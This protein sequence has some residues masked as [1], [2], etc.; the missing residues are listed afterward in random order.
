MQQ[1]YTGEAKIV[2]ARKDHVCSESR[3][4]QIP[5]GSHYLLMVMAPWHEFN[6]S[7]KWVRHKVCLSCADKCGMHT[8]QTLKQLK[9]LGQEL[10]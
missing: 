7:K 1:I 4:H 8:E 9:D 10:P 6:D 3:C 5:K 2:V